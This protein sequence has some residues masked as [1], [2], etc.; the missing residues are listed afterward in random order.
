MSNAKIVSCLLFTCLSHFGCTPQDQALPGN[1]TTALESAFN[2]ND[3][4]AVAALYAD[5]AEILPPDRPAV[6]GISAIQ[7]FYRDEVVRDISFDSTSTWSVVR[8]D[9]AI[10]QGTYKMRDVSQGRDVETGKYLLMWKYIN[11][12]WKVYRQIMNTDSRRSVNVYVDPA[13]SE[14]N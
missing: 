6:T 12:I 3:P 7:S 9:M 8:G 4:T 10:E 11:G 14:P 1:V 2:R 5:D 13:G